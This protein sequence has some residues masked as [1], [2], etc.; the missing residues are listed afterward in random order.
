MTVSDVEHTASDNFS[1]EPRITLSSLRERLTTITGLLFGSSGYH[2]SAYEPL[3]RL[4]RA[5]YASTT[6]ASLLGLL[7]VATSGR[8]DGRLHTAAATVADTQTEYDPHSM[9]WTSFPSSDSLQELPESFKSTALA[10]P[11]AR[12]KPAS[13]ALTVA[14][15]GAAPLAAMPTR[16]LA[17]AP[18][19]VRCLR[20]APWAHSGGTESLCRG[21][22]P[23]RSRKQRTSSSYSNPG[24]SCPSPTHSPRTG[25][26]TRS[27]PTS[28]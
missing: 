21:L 15:A 26:D 20:R 23:C 25:P 13:N 6:P 16:T 14:S 8:T 3:L 9:V 17:P 7:T 12:R 11:V 28:E 1:S 5:I 10:T 22:N 18:Q 27:S 24:L 4:L 2:I 19:H